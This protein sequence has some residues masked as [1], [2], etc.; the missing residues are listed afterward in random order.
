MKQIRPVNGWLVA[1]WVG[2][3][4]LWIGLEGELWR[5]ILLGVW[6]GLLGVWWLGWQGRRWLGGEGWRW[7][8]QLGLGGVL[9]GGSSVGLTL[10]LMVLKTGLHAHGPE[11]SPAEI[12]WV[13]EQW[14]VW[15]VVGGLVGMGVGMLFD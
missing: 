2:Y 11:F 9:W 13:G 8:L 15:M 5:V 4:L 7:W 3:G 14:V 1:G 10:L 6:S 12:G